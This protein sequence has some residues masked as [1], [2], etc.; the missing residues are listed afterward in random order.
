MIQLS[1][2]WKEFAYWPQWAQWLSISILAACLLGMFYVVDTLP[3]KQLLESL[4]QHQIELQRTLKEKQE[5]LVTLDQDM[6]RL[7][8]EQSGLSQLL[9]GIPET[10]EVSGVLEDISQQALAVGLEL[11]SFRVMPEQ[12]E[13][14]YKEIPV[15]ISVVGNY[16]EVAAFMPYLAKLSRIITV[17]DFNITPIPAKMLSHY[18]VREDKMLIM[19]VVLKAYQYIGVEKASDLP[20]NA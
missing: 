2:K 12:D 11:E 1:N 16:Q 6:A 8:Q 7:D 3:Q 10:T 17:H 20:P 4:Q 13:G 19:R 5:A 15:D 18:R 9:K 14:F